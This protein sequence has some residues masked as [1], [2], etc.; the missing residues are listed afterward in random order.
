MFSI[1]MK[2]WSKKAPNTSWALKYFT[3]CTCLFFF[4]TSAT[5]STPRFSKWAVQNC[6]YLEIWWHRRENL[7]QPLTIKLTLCLC[8]PQQVSLCDSDAN[9]R[10]VH[11]E[12]DRIVQGNLLVMQKNGEGLK[13]QP[14]H[15]S[16]YLKVK[17]KCLCQMGKSQRGM[18]L[19][20]ELKEQ[21]QRFCFLQ[22]L[23]W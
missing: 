19:S 6:H 14:Y 12:R 1:G 16:P 4:H 9:A 20:F 11:I 21:N 7:W 18:Y 5:L 10:S 8:W 2:G 15:L 22:L 17:Q 3:Y 23:A 13:G